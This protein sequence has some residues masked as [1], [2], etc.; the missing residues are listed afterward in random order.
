MKN[1]GIEN[2]NKDK[3]LMEKVTM[4]D[5]S[6]PHYIIKWFHYSTLF[7]LF[8][9]IHYFLLII[10]FVNILLLWDYERFLLMQ[11]EKYYCLNLLRTS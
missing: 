5:S 3:L 10:Y 1:N 2:G 7:F 6:I 9:I 11:F 4:F 8:F